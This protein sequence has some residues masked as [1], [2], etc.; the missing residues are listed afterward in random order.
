M[1]ELGSDWKYSG[2][3]RDD[4]KTKGEYSAILYK[5]SEFRAELFRTVWLSDTPDIPS[6]GWDAA[7]V[8]ILN[9]VLFRHI[10]SG[11]N[12]YALNTHLDDQ[13]RVAR[14]KGSELIVDIISALEDNDI[15]ILGGDLNSE[16]DQE[17]YPILSKDLVDVKT[18]VKGN[19]WY[20]NDKTFTGFSDDTQNKRIDYI[21][22]TK[23]IRVEGYAVLS[24]RFDDGIWSSDHRPVVAD[25][26][27]PGKR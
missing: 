17:A 4:G 6:K 19:K 11:R 12:V 10:S 8:R 14:I 7:S 18:V 2:V 15:L 23:K 21:F 1:D 26:V 25:L 24:N 22:T 5:S 3:G 27:I 9:I 20:G 16:P 13:G